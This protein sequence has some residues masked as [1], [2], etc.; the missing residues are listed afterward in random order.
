[1]ISN[2]LVC[3]CSFDLSCPILEKDIYITNVYI[4]LSCLIK[5]RSFFN[6]VCFYYGYMDHRDMEPFALTLVS[7]RSQKTCSLL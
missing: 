1:M 5:W 3:F 6:L 7:L 2:L 4:A